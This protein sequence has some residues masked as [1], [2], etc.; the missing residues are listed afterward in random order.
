M[1]YTLPLLVLT[2]LILVPSTQAQIEVSFAG[3]GGYNFDAEDAM[4]G[5]GLDVD[6]IGQFGP[7]RG[8]GWFDVE[9]VFVESGT[10]IQAD[11]NLTPKYDIGQIEVTLGAGLAWERFSP[12]GGG[13]SISNTGFNVLTGVELNTGSINPFARFRCSIFD[14]NSQDTLFGGVMVGF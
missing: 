7:I 6:G 12:D 9:T 8:G 1:K 3:Y 11:V 13:D 4:I 14:G 2:A 5:L 10:V